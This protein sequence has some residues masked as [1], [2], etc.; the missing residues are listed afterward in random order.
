MKK[1]QW[2][3]GIT[4]TILPNGDIDIPQRDIDNAYD[5]VMGNR[6]SEERFD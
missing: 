2:F 4:C 5:D 3:E 1:S 6:I